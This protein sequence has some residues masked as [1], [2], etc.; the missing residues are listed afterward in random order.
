MYAEKY[1]IVIGTVMDDT[2]DAN[3]PLGSILIFDKTD[4]SSPLITSLKLHSEANPIW[5]II[6]YDFDIKQDDGTLIVMMNGAIGDSGMNV[7]PGR[8]ADGHAPL[9][10]KF[11]LSATDASLTKL[12]GYYWADGLID[13]METVTIVGE[14]FYYSASVW[15]GKRSDKVLPFVMKFSVSDFDH[16]KTYYMKWQI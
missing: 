3:F 12:E 8:M 14:F 11:T 13:A 10:Q 9:L 15:T 16:K 1:L 5:Q 4:T 6:P 7:I 2:Y